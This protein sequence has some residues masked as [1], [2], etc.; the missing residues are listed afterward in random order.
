[1]VPIGKTMTRVLSFSALKTEAQKIFN[2]W[3]LKRDKDEPCIY[4]G[5]KSWGKGP[6][7]AEAAHYLAVSVAESLRYMPDNCHKAHQGCNQ[8]N[9]SYMYRANL[10]NRIGEDN[11]LWLE[12]RRHDLAKFSRFE[13]EEVIEKYKA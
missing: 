8:E 12:E 4:C 10:V 11:V 6:F 1:M 9:D 7:K 3:I 2:A 13:I 5:F